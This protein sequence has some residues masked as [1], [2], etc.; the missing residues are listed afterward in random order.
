MAFLRGG[1]G[2]MWILRQDETVLI[3]Q[4]NLDLAEVGLHLYSESL[5]WYCM[6]N[7]HWEFSKGERCALL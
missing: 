4:I 3:F 6:L 7:V 5:R 2:W 1:D